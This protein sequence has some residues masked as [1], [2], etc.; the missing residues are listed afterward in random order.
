MVRRMLKELSKVHELD[1]SDFNRMRFCIH[2]AC[3]EKYAECIT[4]F[5]TANAGLN[6]DMIFRI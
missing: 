1:D 2:G 5:F 3:Y 6:Q 4:P